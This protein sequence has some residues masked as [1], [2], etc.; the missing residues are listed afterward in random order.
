MV[1]LFYCPCFNFYAC[2]NAYFLWMC[3][4]T[5]AVT[6]EC[7]IIFLARLFFLLCWVI[8]FLAFL[9]GKMLFV[10]SFY[11]HLLDVVAYRC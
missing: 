1:F 4:W 6:W 11:L 9:Y 8:H 10:G 7:R 3:L 5:C 2:F